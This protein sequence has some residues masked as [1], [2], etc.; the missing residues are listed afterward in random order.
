M[1]WIAEKGPGFDRDWFIRA[2]LHAEKVQPQRVTL[3]VPLDWD[4]LRRTFRQAALL[5]ERNAR[6]SE[7]NR[8]DPPNGHDP[9][10]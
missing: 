7:P 2:L 10:R 4:H 9:E 1:A 5:V 8:F 6:E 3:L